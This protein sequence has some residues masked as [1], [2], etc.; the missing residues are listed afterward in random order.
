MAV[1]LQFAIMVKVIKPTPRGSKRSLEA[2][3]HVMD[4]WYKQEND[5][6]A[7]KLL[8]LQAENK[9]LRRASFAWKRNYELTQQQ[10]F[11]AS[12]ERNE[13]ATQVRTLQNLIRE[14]FD[15]HPHIEGEYLWGGATTEEE[16]LEGSE[17][18]SE[19]LLE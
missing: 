5:A 11:R 13:Q 16:I 3:E 17:T 8:Q 2:L 4:N 7:K 9:R 12:R 18:E 1:I 6:Y 14:I 10:Y 19:N 15:G